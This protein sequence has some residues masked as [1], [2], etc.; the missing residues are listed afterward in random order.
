LGEEFAIVMVDRPHFRIGHSLLLLGW[1]FSL[2][3]DLIF[4]VFAEIRQGLGKRD[5]FFGA[6]TLGS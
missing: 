6:D 1:V 5:G 2:H 3:F 4:D